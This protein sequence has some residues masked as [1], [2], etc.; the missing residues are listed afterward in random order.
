MGKLKSGEVPEGQSDEIENKDH[1]LEMQGEEVVLDIVEGTGS[2][3][4]EV[5]APITG[6]TWAGNPKA[7]LSP[8]NFGDPTTG[9]SY[10]TQLLDQAASKKEEEEKKKRPPSGG[11][12]KK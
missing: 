5:T 1:D 7:H 6:P 12:R 2:N 3:V 11:H 10:H 9:K 8:R 4:S